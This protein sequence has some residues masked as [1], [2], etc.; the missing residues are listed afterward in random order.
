M[1]PQKDKKTNP[2]DKFIFW[3]VDNHLDKVALGILITMAVIVRL[4]LMSEVKLSPDYESYY[5]K[6]V[7]EYRERGIIGGLS[8]TIGDYYVPLNIMYAICSLFPCEPYIP[9]TI[10]SGIAEFV[11]AYYLYRI[12]EM[13]LLESG[14]TKEKAKRVGAYMG[15]FSL[16]LPFVVFNGALWKQ[17]DA[18][19]AVF[20]V[21][22][23][24]HLLKEDY[25]KSFIFLALSFGFKLQSIFF[26]PLY[27]VIYMAKKNY[28]ILR[29]LWVPVMYLVMGLP[30]VLLGR[31][32]R[33]TYFSY[34]AQTNET[35]SEGYGMVSF[36]PNFYNFGLDNYDEFLKVPGI[37]LAAAV[38]VA[39][40]VFTIRH[41]RFLDSKTNTLY[42]GVFLGWSCC[43][44]LP[45][46]HERYDYV[47]V[48]L[49]TILFAAAFKKNIWVPIVMNICSF[50]VYAIVLF[51][52][53]EI[54]MIVVSCLEIAAYIYVFTDFTRRVSE[55][56]A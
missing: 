4:A 35:S 29:F 31:G 40:A 39:L 36:Y 9:L 49:A 18:I 48:L 19:Y 37:A 21:I 20:L 1:N 26:V 11:S 43:M 33:A 14:K 32:L 10:F 15:V 28:S 34:L 16:Y 54:S 24:F 42:L 44:F 5:L 50:L 41:K 30:S 47:I 22:A 27:L 13:L 38:L 56:D 8:T 46:M 45:G 51:R 12:V 23:I 53:E 2:I 7:M 6:W 25:N 55:Y 17:C 52:S 3:L